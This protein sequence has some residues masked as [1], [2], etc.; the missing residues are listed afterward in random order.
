MMKERQEAG[1]IGDD[2]HRSV[3]YQLKPSPAGGRL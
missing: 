2:A 1:T 3:V